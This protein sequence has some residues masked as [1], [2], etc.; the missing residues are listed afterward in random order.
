M[1]CQ[2]SL[3][4]LAYIETSK[5]PLQVFCNFILYL[6]LKAPNQT[7]RAD[8]IKEQLQSDFGISMPHQIISNCTR[9]LERK[10]EVIRLPH[11]AGYKIGDT[12]FDIDSFENTRQRFA[13][14]ENKLLNSLVEF[15]SSQYKQKWSEEEAKEYLSNFATVY[16]GNIIKNLIMDCQSYTK[17]RPNE[18]TGGIFV[19][20]RRK[21]ELPTGA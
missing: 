17:Y 18:T 10:Q 15:V 3:V 7:L 6:L 14:H 8:E 13:E 21:E 12:S 4:S 1:N 19:S 16:K 5:N 20:W 9:I 2:N 11:A